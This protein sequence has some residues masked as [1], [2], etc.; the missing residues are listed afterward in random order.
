MFTRPVIMKLKTNF[1]GE[2]H[3]MKEH[4]MSSLYAMRRANGD[5]FALDERGRFRVPVF[6]SSR[7]GMLA[8]SRHWGMILFKPVALDERA[9]EEFAATEA[10]RAARFWLID[11]PSA[12][13]NRGQLIDHAQL[14]LLVH[15]PIEQ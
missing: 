3:G 6:R 5:W 1:A 12:K 2:G 15:G 9:L 11:D 10:D 4:T 7:D 14:A 13:L 8:R